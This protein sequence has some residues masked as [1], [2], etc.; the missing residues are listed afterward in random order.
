MFS[1]I[2]IL[3]C[4]CKDERKHPITPFFN[5]GRFMWDFGS[6]FLRGAQLSPL[7]WVFKCSLCMCLWNGSVC[8]C[9]KCCS[10]RQQSCSCCWDRL[11]SWVDLHYPPHS[12]S[13]RQTYR[14]VPAL[15][16]SQLSLIF[17]RQTAARAMSRPSRHTARPTVTHRATGGNTMFWPGRGGER[18]WERGREEDRERETDTVSREEGTQHGHHHDYPIITTAMAAYYHSHN[19]HHHFTIIQLMSEDYMHLGWSQ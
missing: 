19:H 12:C 9:E 7:K 3:L 14:Q 13:D 11:Q 17:L 18:D 10:E 15:S 4:L 1:L 8:S 5:L 2:F 16:S 6:C